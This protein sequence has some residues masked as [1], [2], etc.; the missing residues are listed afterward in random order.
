LIFLKNC[1][2]FQVL[3]GLYTAVKREKGFSPPSY[4]AIERHFSTAQL[5][6]RKDSQ[7]PRITQSNATSPLDV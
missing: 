2:V 5:K 1:L 4:H 7:L 6:E 3:D